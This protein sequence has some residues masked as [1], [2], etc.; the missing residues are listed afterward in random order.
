MANETKRVIW[1]N[2]CNMATNNMI[3]YRGTEQKDG[4]VYAVFYS[5]CCRCKYLKRGTKE[6]NVVSI[7]SYNA[8]ISREIYA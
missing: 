7:A 1:C 4:V 8:L 6:K 5:R 2:C 3:E